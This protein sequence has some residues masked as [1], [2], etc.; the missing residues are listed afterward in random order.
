MT[1]LPT[2]LPTSL[3]ALLR[4][5]QPRIHNRSLLGLRTFIDAIP[6]SLSG[7]CTVSSRHKKAIHDIRALSFAYFSVLAFVKRPLPL[8]N[9]LKFYSLADLQIRM[10]RYLFRSNNIPTKVLGRLSPSQKRKQLLADKP[11]SKPPALPTNIMA[12]INGVAS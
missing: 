12:F 1:V 10:K 8:Y 11:M 9:T 6:L 3:I 4:L 5:I 7:R 2:L